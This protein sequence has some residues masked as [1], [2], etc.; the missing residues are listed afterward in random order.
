MV[1][2]TLYDHG[3]EA[4]QPRQYTMSKDKMYIPEMNTMRNPLRIFLWKGLPTET[5]QISKYKYVVRNNVVIDCYESNQA[6]A[7]GNMRTKVT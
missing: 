6:S 7:E 3:F 4:W 1:I 2:C 5:V